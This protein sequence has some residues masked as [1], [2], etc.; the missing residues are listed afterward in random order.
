MTMCD[1]AFNIKIGNLCLSHLLWNNLE[2]CQFLAKLENT[3]GVPNGRPYKNN[4]RPLENAKEKL[5][6]AHQ[7]NQRGKNCE[8]IYLISLKTTSTSLSASTD[9]KKTGH[10]D[11]QYSPEEDAVMIGC[12]SLTNWN[13]WIPIHSI[14]LFVSILPEYQSQEK[15][16]VAARAL[17]QFAKE[18]YGLT[19]IWAF[20]HFNG[21]IGA[22]RAFM[23][24]IGLQDKGWAR[25]YGL[26]GVIYAT[27]K[28]NKKTIMAEGSPIQYDDNLMDLG[29]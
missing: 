22:P 13:R 11:P 3:L 29:A 20:V 16:T 25:R 23:D 12:I 5:H 21:C 10:N 17:L 15:G 27:S 26:P 6:Y 18:N 24:K 2:H 1:P 14:E 9:V 28:M 8:G 7:V 19:E 4:T